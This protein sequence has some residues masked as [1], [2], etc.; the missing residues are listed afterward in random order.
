[1]NKSFHTD[2]VQIIVDVIFFIYFVNPHCRKKCL[3]KELTKRV[4][5]S[6]FKIQ[7]NF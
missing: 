2:Q 7:N 4:I 1:M 6:I 5:K 3:I